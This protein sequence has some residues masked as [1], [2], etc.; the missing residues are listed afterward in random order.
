MNSS[1]TCSFEARSML[2]AVVL[3]KLLRTAMNIIPGSSSPTIE[4]SLAIQNFSS[5]HLLSEYTRRYGEVQFF[6]GKT[7]N[8]EILSLVEDVM[9]ARGKSHYQSILKICEAIVDGR[10]LEKKSVFA[11]LF[12]GFPLHIFL[13][14]KSFS[15]EHGA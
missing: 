12:S 4:N 8:M 7:W 6:D 1:I 9:E 13:G 15:P 11:E 5:E 3:K 2:M 10:D 14:S